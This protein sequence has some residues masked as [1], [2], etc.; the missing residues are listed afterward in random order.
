VLKKCEPRA[1]FFAVRRSPFAAHAARSSQLT[2]HS[3]RSHAH[4]VLVLAAS[5]LAGHNLNSLWSIVLIYCITLYI[6]SRI[7][8]VTSH[9]MS[10]ATCA[11]CT[12]ETA[13]CELG[14]RWP[15][16]EERSTD[17][18]SV[19]NGECE[20]ATLLPAT[21]CLLLLVVVVVVV[22]ALLV[23]LAHAPAARGSRL[24]PATSRNLT[25]TANNSVSGCTPRT[26]HLVWLWL[27]LGN[28]ELTARMTTMKAFT[29]KASPHAARPCGL[30]QHKQQ[31]RSR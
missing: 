6:V 7:T 2:A 12:C 1:Y 13:S 18:Y 4:A 23:A 24:A 21:C 27:R 26:P 31:V 30:Q 19:L 17:R 20:P 8:G 10:C 3:S 11:P 15:V 28:W 22:V 14:A 29:M 25:S 16:S 5:R 9:H